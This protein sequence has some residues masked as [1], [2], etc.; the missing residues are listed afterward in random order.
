MLHRPAN[1][2]ALGCLAFWLSMPGIVAAA[3]EAARPDPRPVLEITRDT[4]LDPAKTYGPIVI[5]A[6]SVTIDGRRSV[7]D[8]R[9]PRM[10][11]G[12]TRIPTQTN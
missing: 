10:K 11:H 8:R 9:H 2:Y 7:G 6:S 1:R 4:V 12:S 5:R 3:Q